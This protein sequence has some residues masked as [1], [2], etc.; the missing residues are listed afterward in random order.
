MSNEFVVRAGAKFRVSWRCS[1]TECREFE[2]VYKGMS[3]VGSDTVLVFD[4]GGTLRF[5]SAQAIVCMDQ[6]EA[7]PEED[8][9]KKSDVGSIFYG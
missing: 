7:A 9:K 8:P 1:A 3:A 4:L 6:L 2:G 5:L